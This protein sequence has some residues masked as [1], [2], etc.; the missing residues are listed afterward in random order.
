MV[1]YGKLFLTAIFWGGTFV[2]ARVVAQ[3]VAP[4]SASFLRFLTASIFL[5]AMMRPAMRT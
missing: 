1:V 3:Y 4:Y 5:I 2:A